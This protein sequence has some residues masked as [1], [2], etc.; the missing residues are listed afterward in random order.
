MLQVSL[1][2]KQAYRTIILYIQ[3]D[4]QGHLQ[5][6]RGRF[7]GKVGFTLALIPLVLHRVVAAV[8]HA[9]AAVAALAVG[10]GN[11]L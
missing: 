2:K 5:R 8:K 1:F 11:L 6:G 10:G 3:T 9:D 7:A 4:P